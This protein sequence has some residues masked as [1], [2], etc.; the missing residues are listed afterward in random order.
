MTLPVHGYVDQTPDGVK[1]VNQNKLIEELINRQIDKMR[2]MPDMDQRLIALA[3]TDIQRG[4]MALNRAVFQPT[5]LI[6]P[7][8]TQELFKGLAQ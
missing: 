5:R 1:V 4:F 3:F 7:I 6:G 2:A 8:D